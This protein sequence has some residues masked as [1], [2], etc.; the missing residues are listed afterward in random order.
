MHRIIL[1]LVLAARI[2]SA[3][4]K[5]DNVI[6]LARAWAKVK[7]FHPYLAYKDIDWDAAL[8]AAIPKAEAATTEAQYKAAVDGMLAVLHDPVTHV[9][10]RAPAPPPRPSSEWLT[11]PAPG[12][13]EVDVFSMLAT[14]GATSRIATEEAKAKTLILD[15]RRVPTR[16]VDALG[17]VLPA[18]ETWPSERTIEHHGFRTQVGMTSGGYFETFVTTEDHGPKRAGKTAPG[19]VVFIVSAA[20]DLPPVAMALQAGGAAVILADDK[21]VEDAI[22]STIDVPLAMGLFAHIRVGEPLWGVPIADEVAPAK[23]LPARALALAKGAWRGKK[24]PPLTLPPMHVRDDDGYDGK[25]YPSRELRMLAGIRAWAVLA[26]FNPYKQFAPQWD[27]VLEEFLPRLAAAPDR[28]AYERT[29][30]MLA[31]RAGDGH[32]GVFSPST[33]R[34]WPAID[35]RIVEGKLA[36]TRVYGTEPGVAVGDVIEKIDGK[37]T[38]QALAAALEVT[39]GSTDEAR[40]QRAAQNALVG[41][42]GTDITFTLRHAGGAVHDVKLARKPASAHISKEPHWKKLANNVGYADLRTLTPDEVPAM[43][44]DLGKTT[45]IIFDMRGYP[46]GTAWPIAPRVNTRHA[47]YGAEFLQPLVTAY[48]EFVDNRVRFLQPLPTLPEGASIYTGRVVVLIDDRAIS[49][50]E[51]SCLFFHEA[52]GARFVGSTTHGANGDVTMFRLPG[53]LAMTFTGQEVRWADGH[54]LQRVGVKP[55]VLVRPTL[56]G[57]RSGS[58]EVL[59]RALTYWRDGK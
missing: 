22:A 31:T 7:F 6:G 1:A 46:N 36:I 23:T 13:L 11:W 54:Q 32:V 59:D 18:I 40:T 56:A 17:E 38:E 2:A 44:A 48:G 39:T 25:P 29:L 43:F 24:H 10:E 34:S 19:H 27:H 41:N 8:I 20:D 26:T 51:H 12:V 15:V 28:A 47:K 4:S 42:E 37:P 35:A 49:Q 9:G 3:D 52:A 33:V 30:R 14:S 58:D 50:A 45:A 53:G 5:I 57:I 55:D 16:E 21:L